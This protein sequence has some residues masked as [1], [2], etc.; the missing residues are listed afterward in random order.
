M[1][2]ATRHV[3]LSEYPNSSTSQTH[4]EAQQCW[5]YTGKPQDTGGYQHDQKNDNV[6]VSQDIQ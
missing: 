4:A 5:R 2:Q 1:R 6:C 3:A